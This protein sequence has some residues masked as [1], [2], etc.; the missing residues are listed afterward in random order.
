MTSGNRSDRDAAPPQ[1]LHA[2]VNV[3][4]THVRWLTFNG[5]EPVGEGRLVTAELSR[6]PPP[7][8]VV[9]LVSVVPAASQQLTGHWQ[10]AGAVVHLLDATSPHGLEVAYEPPG[11]LGAD[12]LMNAVALWARRG[13]GIVIDLGTATT[14]TLVDV[15]GRLRGGAILPGLSMARDA[16]WRRT[17]QLP[18][19][20]L[21]VPGGA[22]GASTVAA[23]QAGIVLGHVGALQHLVGRLRQEAPGATALLL[24]GGWGALLA[25]ELPEAEWCPDLGLAGARR[26]LARLSGGS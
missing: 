11:A 17:A 5:D 19:V 13:P 18:E 8:P 10:A 1:G 20:P 14:L 25:P 23:L 16:L 2:V 15:A 6:V 3:G 4:N 22:L 9:G 24:T 26:V 12:R 21:V 7:A